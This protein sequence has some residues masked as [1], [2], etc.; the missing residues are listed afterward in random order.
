MELGDLE[1]VEYDMFSELLDRELDNKEYAKENVMEAFL[2]V[3]L[4]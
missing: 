1:N 3:M 2:V 4:I